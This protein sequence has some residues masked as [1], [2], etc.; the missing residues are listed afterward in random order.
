MNWLS[1]LGFELIFMGRI[2]VMALVE[3][4]STN[5]GLGGVFWEKLVRLMIRVNV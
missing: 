2:A 4:L 1:L 5:E 3:N